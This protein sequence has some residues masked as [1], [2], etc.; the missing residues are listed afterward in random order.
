M[1]CILTKQFVHTNLWKLSC[2]RSKKARRFDYVARCPFLCVSI[3]VPDSY[4]Y[5]LALSPLELYTRYYFGGEVDFLTAVSVWIS[6]LLRTPFLLL[7]RGLFRLTRGLR[8]SVGERLVVAVYPG[9]SYLCARCEV[10]TTSCWYP[11]RPC[12]GWSAVN[13]RIVEGYSRFSSPS[14][15]ARPVCNFY[16]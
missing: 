7:N 14:H 4:C 2:L 16:E 3:G 15:P 5:R 13:L 11:H 10:K 8:V 6:G 12:M 1:E 9:V